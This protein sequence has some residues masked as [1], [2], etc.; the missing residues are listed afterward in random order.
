MAENINT[1]IGMLDSQ[2]EY[3][4]KIGMAGDAQAIKVEAEQLKMLVALEIP[5]SS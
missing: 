2:A 1:L 4:S 5:S 3:L